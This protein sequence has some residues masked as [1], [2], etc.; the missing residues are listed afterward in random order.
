V[1]CNE[2]ECVCACSNACFRDRIAGYL[3]GSLLLTIEAFGRAKMAQNAACLWATME[4]HGS[5]L[6]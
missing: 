3:R 5:R 6:S 4:V 1:L 2:R